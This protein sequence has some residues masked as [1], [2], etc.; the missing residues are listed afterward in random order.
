M[1]SVFSNREQ[2]PLLGMESGTSDIID[3]Y[4]TQTRHARNNKLQGGRKYRE[5]K[6]RFQIWAC[7]LPINLRGSVC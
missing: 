4:N 7:S 3:T 2:N 5:K 1:S 6:E